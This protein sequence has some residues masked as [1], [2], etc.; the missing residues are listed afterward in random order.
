MHI[1]IWFIV[2]YNFVVSVKNGENGETTEEKKMR[3]V[4]GMESEEPT[5]SET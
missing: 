4:S 5:S 1:C 2:G 3:Q